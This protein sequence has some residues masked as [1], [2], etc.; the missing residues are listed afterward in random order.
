MLADGRG[1][2]A[3]AASNTSRTS[4]RPRGW[5]R[6]GTRPDFSGAVATGA[7]RPAAGER[8]SSTATA[9]SK[10]SCAA[11]VC[12][13]EELVLIHGARRRRCDALN[14][15]GLRTVVVTNQPAA[16]ARGL[17]SSDKAAPH[18][19]QAGHG[20][21]ARG[22][23]PR[24]ALSLPASPAFRN[25]RRG[26]RG[27]EDPT[28]RAASR[29]T[30]W[31][32]RLKAISISISPALGISATRRR[33]LGRPK[34]RAC[35]PFWWR[36]GTA[37]SIAAILTKPNS[38]SRT[39]RRRQPSSS[40]SIRRSRSCL[41]PQIAAMASGDDWFIGGA[42]SAGKSTVA[43]TLERELRLQGRRARIIHTDRWIEDDA[44]RHALASFDMS[45]LKAAVAIAAERPNSPIRYA[46]AS[47][48]ARGTPIGDQTG[49]GRSPDMGRRFRRGACG[50]SG[51]DRSRHRR[52][53]ERSR[54]T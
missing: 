20:A 2:T 52:R 44:D 24:R 9:C 1:C 13:P 40:T 30:G 45:S 32:F 27:P 36:P 19:R 54:P 10:T 4:A 31:S 43:A 11:H 41:A 38:P 37:A 53:L 49:A 42:P 18:T 12:T 47:G 3:I 26:G 34:K 33:I 22:G 14:Q 16:G 17:H 15:A 51:P 35:P 7:A 39:F 25:P 29:N 21:G 46:H 48:R 23:L 28:A 8:C 5:T 50:V 6:H